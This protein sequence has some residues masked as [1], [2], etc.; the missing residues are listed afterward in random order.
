MGHMA[1]KKQPQARPYWL[2][3][4]ITGYVSVGIAVLTVIFVLG[5]IAVVFSSFGE[6]GPGYRNNF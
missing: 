2:T 4:L 1:Q 3:G 5:F 6:I